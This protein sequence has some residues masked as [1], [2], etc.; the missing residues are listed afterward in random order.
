MAKRKPSDMNLLIAVD[1]PAG[2][3]SHDVV[4]RVRR[5]LRERRVGH[6]GTLDP[7][8]T[9]VMLVG[10]G[11]ATRLL[12]L[13]TLD[14]KS[15]IATIAFGAR[16]NTDDSEGEVVCRAPVPDE[17]ADP[18]VAT[19]LLNGFLGPQMQVPPAFS[20]ISVDGVRSYKRARAG[21]DVELP[22]RPIE[23][24][25]AQL[26]GIAR[27][28]DGVPLTWTVAFTVSK[29]SYIRALARDL[30]T[31]AH[32]AAHLIDLR[33]TAS[34]P[35]TLTDCVQLD[36]LAPDTV[37]SRMIDPVRA[38]GIPVRVIDEAEA[39]RVR[40]GRALI[41]RADERGDIALTH[42]DALVAIAREHDGRLTMECVFPQPVEGVR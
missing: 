5:A 27:A 25:A 17:L 28:T 33:R 42:R 26:L 41:A 13:L 3:T 30:G 39:M 15:Y 8:A 2:I 21:E 1:K 18:A 22:A 12:G 23:V 11:Q 10:V 34:G 9:G 6:A 16:T 35:I 24:L 14:T 38:L 32:S 4:A 37:R 20:A 40:D 36:D 29:G 7:A 31:R 19:A